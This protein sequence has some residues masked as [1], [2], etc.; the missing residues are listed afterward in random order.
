M[1]DKICISNNCHSLPAKNLKEIY[2]FKIKKM[3][4]FMAI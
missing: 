4:D 3:E 2:T 1:Y